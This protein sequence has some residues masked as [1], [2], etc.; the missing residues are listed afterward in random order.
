MI[1]KNPLNEELSINYKGTHYTVGPKATVEVPDA[2]AFYWHDHIHE[3]LTISDKK[4]V[5][6]KTPSVDPKVEVKKEKE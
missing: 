4:E 1:I 6:A 2:V 5:P 3:F